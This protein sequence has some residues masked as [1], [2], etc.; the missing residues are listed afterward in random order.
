[1]RT[2][3]RPASTE[4][5]MRKYGLLPTTAATSSG[6]SANAAISTSAVSYGEIATRT[7]VPGLN[8][9]FCTLIEN[10]TRAAAG[11]AACLPSSSTRGARSRH[12]DFI[13]A[14]FDG[15]AVAHRPDGRWMSGTLLVLGAPGGGSRR[16]CRRVRRRRGRRRRRLVRRGGRGRGGGRMRRDGGR[17]RG[18]VGR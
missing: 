7:G 11:T 16:R 4:S 18:R 13:L 2:A 15:A 1:M 14:P 9:A 17:R 3:R 6:D 12:S 8:V 5:A 10:G